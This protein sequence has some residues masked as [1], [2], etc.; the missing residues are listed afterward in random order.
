MVNSS[1]GFLYQIKRFDYEDTE[2]QCRQGQGGGFLTIVAEVPS[3]NL[4]TGDFIKF[5]WKIEKRKNLTS[6]YILSQPVLNNTLQ[7]FS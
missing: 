3:Y 6:C 5:I 1:S 2:I 4:F 7:W